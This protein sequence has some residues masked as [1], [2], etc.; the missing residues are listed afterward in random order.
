MLFEQVRDSHN[1]IHD[2]DTA[3]AFGQGWFETGCI[4]AH[5]QNMVVEGDELRVFVQLPAPGESATGIWEE[6]RGRSA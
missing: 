6:K 2:D 5:D 4:G 3:A 1:S